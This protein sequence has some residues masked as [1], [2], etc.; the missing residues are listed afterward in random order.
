[1]VRER[2][3]PLGPSSDQAGAGTQNSA[4]RWTQH[5]LVYSDL[6]LVHGV[7][8]HH[9]QPRLPFAQKPLTFYSW[10]SIAPPLWFLSLAVLFRPSAAVSVRNGGTGTPSRSLPPAAAS[11]PALGCS[12]LPQSAAAAFPRPSRALDLLQNRAGLTISSSL[13]RRFPLAS[14]SLPAPALQIFSWIKA[15]RNDRDHPAG[16]ISSGCGWRLH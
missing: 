15:E 6:P 14:S 8:R 13:A 2:N 5:C 7:T 16:L 12:D 1:M 4:Q 3:E 9:L 11:P 10:C